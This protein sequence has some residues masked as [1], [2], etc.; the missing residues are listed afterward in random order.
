MLALALTM[1]M[2]NI[3]FLCSGQSRKVSAAAILP[4]CC[5]N[6]GRQPHYGDVFSCNAINCDAGLHARQWSRVLVSSGSPGLDDEGGDSRTLDCSCH[7][8]SI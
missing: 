4:I 2:A 5:T 1:F 7:I 3:P 8:C 6:D